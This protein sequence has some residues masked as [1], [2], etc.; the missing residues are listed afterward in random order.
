MRVSPNPG[1]DNPAPDGCE[2]SI[3]ALLAHEALAWPLDIGWLGNP[4][5]DGWYACC[6]NGPAAAT[7]SPSHG[8]LE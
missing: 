3:K 8:E 7:P 2:L 6:E 5:A 4:K 1:L